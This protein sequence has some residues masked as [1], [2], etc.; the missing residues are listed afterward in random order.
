MYVANNE[1]NIYMDALLR[2]AGSCNRVESP[3][4]TATI[5]DLK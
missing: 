4:T 3:N 1:G 5:L 2:Q